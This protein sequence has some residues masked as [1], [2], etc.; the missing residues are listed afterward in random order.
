MFLNWCAISTSMQ[1]TSAI[2]DVGAGS[3]QSDHPGWQR[4]GA[5][6]GGA[7]LGQGAGQSHEWLVW[8]DMGMGEGWLLLLRALLG[9]HGGSV[10]PL[11]LGMGRRWE[12]AAGFALGTTLHCY[13][14]AGNGQFYY[15]HCLKQWSL[16]ALP[17]GRGGG[18]MIIFLPTH[19][20]ASN[21]REILSKNVLYLCC[22]H[23]KNC[24]QLYFPLNPEAH[25]LLL[26]CTDLSTDKF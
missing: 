4:E 3:K 25:L 18:S 7:H 14:T 23:G 22:R 26:I 17:L 20:I 8:G 2:A 9:K 24:W 13:S 10:Y 1:E 21:R 19:R 11:D 12:A 6:T 15:P 5:P 16:V